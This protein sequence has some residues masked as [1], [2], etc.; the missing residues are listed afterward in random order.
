[1]TECFLGLGIE[2]YTLIRYN[3]L[4]IPYYLKL[5]LK[6]VFIISNVIGILDKG[7]LQAFENLSIMTILV[8][9]DRCDTYMGL[10]SL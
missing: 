4:G 6:T 3:F 1:M 9:L 8:V 2:M 7:K 5:S 10:G